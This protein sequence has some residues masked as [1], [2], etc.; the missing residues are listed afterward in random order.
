MDNDKIT[1]EEIETKVRETVR[2]LL[3]E[4]LVT[5]INEIDCE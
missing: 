3:S 4:T 2:S 5:E 1:K